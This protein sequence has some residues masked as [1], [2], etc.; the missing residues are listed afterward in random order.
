MS[1]RNWKE[2]KQQPGTAGPGNILGCCLVSLRFLSD[3]D[4]VHKFLEPGS[5]FLCYNIAVY[6]DLKLNAIFFR[7]N[8][9]GDSWEK[10]HANMPTK[11]RFH[12]AMYVTDICD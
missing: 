9:E 8:K 1:H 7:Y 4:P 3:I 12:S 11:M 5:S 10:F 6:E 2:T